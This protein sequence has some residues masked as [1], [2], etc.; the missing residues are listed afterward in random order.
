MARERAPR[1][2]AVAKKAAQLLALVAATIVLPL[3]C[4]SAPLD[5]D[6]EAL[7]QVDSPL[8]NCGTTLGSAALQNT[9][10]H[11]WLG[12]F[13]DPGGIGA[14]ATPIAASANLNFAG[15]TPSMASPQVLYRVSLPGAPGSNQS[16]I[17][18]TPTV[19][20]DY[21]I[22]TSVDANVSI[23]G[24]GGATVAATLNNNIQTSCTTIGTSLGAGA[25]GTALTRVRVFPLVAGNVYRVVFGPVGVS[26]FNVL[27]DEPNDYL[28]LYFADL[29]S[30]TFGDPNNPSVSECT[31]PSGQVANELDCDDQNAAINPNA[32]ENATDG[33]DNDCDGL[34]D[35]EAATSDL[36]VVSVTAV[37]PVQ[38][39]LV[40]QTASVSVKTIV[41]NNDVVPTDGRVTRTTSVSGSGATVTPAGSVVTTENNI[42]LAEERA[43]LTNLNVNCTSAG[44]T[45]VTVAA[46][47]QPARSID[48]DPNSANNSGSLSFA[49]ECVACMH[50]L[51]SVAL[52][53]RTTTTVGQ[54]LGGRAFQLGSDN[55]TATVTADVAVNGNA[56]LRSSSRING[57]LTMSGTLSNQGPYTVTGTIRPRT[58]VTIPPI[59]RMTVPVGTT[60][61]RANAGTTV[62]WSPGTYRD[63]LIQQI[64]A[65]QPAGIANLSAGVYNLSSLTLEPDARM[66]LNTTGGDIFINVE[67]A[68][69]VG[70]RSRLIKTG[71][72]QVAIYTNATGTVRLGTDIQFNAS[73]SAPAALLQVYSRT[74]INGC[75]AANQIDYQPDVVQNS[76]NLPRT[77][78]LPLLPLPPSTCSNGTMDGDE[79]GVDCGGSCL[80]TCPP[81]PLPISVTLPVTSNWASGYCVNVSVRNNGTRPTLTWMATLNVGPTTINNSWNGNFSGAT[82]SITVAPLGFNGVINPGQTLTSAGFCAT[83]PAGNTTFLPSVVSA[84]GY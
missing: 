22:A 63:G 33:I 60:D 13:G 27:I 3:G 23:L 40:G 72:G 6:A 77:F 37:T 5:E 43:L 1:N 10:G 53:D 79:T 4:T 45:T 58:P 30:D 25:P 54:L 68:F 66:N 56:F 71:A 29:D 15:A 38:R 48:V 9:C 20:Q 57:N 73:L 39:L 41:S 65:G 70:D 14:Q 64:T 44:V 12:P 55:A 47:I 82:G 49:I 24:P 81:P 59:V 50:A 78:P 34:I 52:A 51:Q 84:T 31:V 61:I 7:A 32:T 80:N 75:T 69:N 26:Q 35:G 83:R 28:N 19:T 76:S 74:T 36:R 67:G 21:A 42:R 17:K 11:G 16:A 18:F 2:L 46:S 62:T 8:V